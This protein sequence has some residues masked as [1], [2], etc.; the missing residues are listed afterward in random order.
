MLRIKS[1]VSNIVWK[2]SNVALLYRSR[3]FGVSRRR[4]LWNGGGHGGSPTTTTTPSIVPN[5]TKTV[6]TVMVMMVSGGGMAY[7][8]YAS[9][10]NYAGSHNSDQ[11]SF[12]D[13]DSRDRTPTTI[14]VEDPNNKINNDSIPPSANV[15]TIINHQ[16]HHASPSSKDKSGNNIRDKATTTFSSVIV[17]TIQS[18][19]RISRLIGTCLIITVDYKLIPFYEQVHRV[20]KLYSKTTAG[21]SSGHDSNLEQQQQQHEYWEEQ[22]L[23]LQQEFD[24]A[25]TTY[26]TPTPQQLQLPIEERVRI[27]RNEKEQ[28]I[29]A[30]QQLT[31]AQEQLQNIT[32]TTT[33][34]TEPTD[35][36]STT[37]TATATSANHNTKTAT[38]KTP[39]SIRSAVHLRCAQRLLQLCQ[40]N[41][42]VYIKIGQHLANLDYLV[43]TEYITTLSALYDQNPVSHYESDVCAVFREEFHGALPTDIFHRFDPVPIASASLAQVH[44]AYDAHG[45]KY[46]VKVQHYGLRET[47]RGDIISLNFA[48]QMAEY[49]FTK[50]EFSFR[51]IADEM[52]PNLPKELDFFNEGANAERA[53]AFIQ[54]TKLPCIIPKVHWDKT[55][56]R[57]LTMDFEEGC[58]ITDIDRIQKMGFRGNYPL[59]ITKLVTSIFASQI[60]LSGFVHCDPHPANVL[61]RKDERTGQPV[62][63]LVDHGLYKSI[64]TDFRLQYAQLW[65]SLM[66]ANV[67]DIIQS[68]YDLGM[69]KS[70]PGTNERNN[71]DDACRLFAGVITARPFDEV[72]ERSNRNKQ[73]FNI[74]S[75]LFG[76]A[77]QQRS[78]DPTD[79]KSDQAIIRGY[80]QRFLPNIM[81]LLS[82]LPRPVLLLLKM[83]DCLR[84]IEYTLGGNST[85]TLMVNGHYAAY[86]LYQQELVVTSSW[87]GKFRAWW[88]YL[89]ITTRIHLNEMILWWMERL[90]YIA[91]V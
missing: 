69:P 38:A 37:D 66:L 1:V 31:H 47:S 16:S 48:V 13:S 29:Q 30:A 74:G 7:H 55:S 67:N 19:Q 5:Y 82:I 46:A 28:M 53:A 57:V 73:R 65:K 88:T 42:G 33:S 84:H 40:S 59:Y 70:T 89:K 68:C 18:L 45:K 75:W 43:P 6:T 26:S 61:I 25:Q 62:I 72:I 35:T 23:R 14:S 87:S 85:N 34:R 4:F 27:K 81:A 32:T 39:T 10:C 60:F 63:V 17:P 15:T 71:N 44:V 76:G 2:P 54:T 50:Q 91:N 86:A 11:I 3:S 49:I 79:S 56:E 77:K 12:C 20:Q 83:N 22:V 21:Q 9:V 8:Y 90:P 80:A 51:W 52:A 24:Q 58:N 78:S 64:D 41:R 36:F